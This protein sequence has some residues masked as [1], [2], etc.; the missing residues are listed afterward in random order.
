MS[1][2]THEPSHT[3]LRPHVANLWLAGFNPK[4][5]NYADDC[6]LACQ[7]SGVSWERM[8]I[9]G[10]VRT[11]CWRKTNVADWFG[12]GFEGPDAGEQ[13]LNG[14]I[15]WDNAADIEEL[16]GTD[17]NTLQRFDIV[18]D[19]W[20]RFRDSWLKSQEGQPLPQPPPPPPPKPE[21]VQP[22]P[23]PPK[24]EEPKPPEAPKPPRNWKRS[25][26]WIGTAAT[27]A[28]STF[29]LWGMALPPGVKQVV[30]AIL[31]AISGAF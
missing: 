21:P 3:A 27:I 17:E 23:P 22:P 18:W 30:K 24:P 29:F 5:P 13:V 2:P 25:L 16:A 1:R 19:R 28:G 12:S 26:K 4:H 10:V 6:F 31:D 14:A 20:S 8:F 9:F 7:G 15:A 11:D